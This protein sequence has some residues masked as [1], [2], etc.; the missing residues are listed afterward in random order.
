V[1]FEEFVAWLGQEFLQ[2]RLQEYQVGDLLVQRR[3]FDEN[4]S[5]LESEFRNRAVGYVANERQIADSVGPLL[6]LAAEAFPSRM[7]YFEPI[8]YRIF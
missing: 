1:T 6:D 2:G 5:V 3:L 8:G 4:R 7:L